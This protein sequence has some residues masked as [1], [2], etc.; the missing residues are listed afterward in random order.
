[1]YAVAGG[2]SAPAVSGTTAGDTILR[3][4][5]QKIVVSANSA[6]T[7]Q[8]VFTPAGF[9]GVGTTD[10]QRALHVVGPEGPVASFPTSGA[11]GTRDM[12]VMENNHN[13]NLT[14][15]NQ[16]AGYG[17]S[18]RFLKSGDTTTTGAIYYTHAA[19]LNDSLLSFTVGGAERLRLT[20]GRAG[21]GTATPISSLQ[22]YS[23]S[24][25]NPLTAAIS[26]A[27]GKEG[28][29]TLNAGGLGQAGAGGGILFGGNGST[30][31]F[32]AIKSLLN[33][34]GNN[35]TGELA[36]ATRNAT[37]DTALT[38]RMRITSTGRVGIG[39]NAPNP[40]YL[41]HVQ[42][43]GRFDGTVSG[44]NISAVYQDVAEWVPAN[45]ALTA[46]TVV[47]ID[48]SAPNTVA[49]STVAYDTAVAGVVS[50][51]PGIILGVAGPNKVQVATT[52]RVKVRADARSGPIAPGDLLVTSDTPGVVMRSEPMSVNGRTFHQPGTLV[53][54][55]LEPL[56][57]G[58]GEILVLLS[59]Q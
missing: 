3:A 26:D 13:A 32:A 53:G 59:L 5:N 7:G 56:E 20:G 8:F 6:A 51:Q 27:G 21:F 39:P 10:P 25:D 44:T 14:F 24:G 58:T 16:G 45:D 35:T 46:G 48:R 42:G 12:L 36:F 19:I 43:N 33:D 28:L 23:N 50:G 37:T 2:A 18:I 52:G 49:A 11:M 4:D 29:L 22:H 34:G 41:L 9:L 57:K 54:K 31:F 1:M 47:V 15:I 40:A 38:E 55:A 17:T 30:Q